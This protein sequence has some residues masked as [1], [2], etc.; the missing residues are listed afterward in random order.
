MPCPAN[1]LGAIAPLDVVAILVAQAILPVPQ[2]DCGFASVK[3]GSERMRWVDFAVW[4][5][6]AD[7]VFG[8]GM[9]CPYWETPTAKRTM[10]RCLPSIC[11]L[12][13][14]AAWGTG[15]IACAT[16][17]QKRKNDVIVRQ[18]FAIWGAAL[19]WRRLKPTLLKGVSAGG[20]SRASRRR[21]GS[22]LGLRGDGRSGA[23]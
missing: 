19:Q 1:E 2:L 17:R 20:G 9:P 22:S 21:R 8:H 6:R 18:V 10:S 11:V 16:E 12:R 14:V 13:R 4:R 7:G 15:R 23:R 3:R 5:R